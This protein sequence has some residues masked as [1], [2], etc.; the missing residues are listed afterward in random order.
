[1]HPVKKLIF[2][3]CL[4]CV[5]AVGSLNAQTVDT[6][7]IRQI[8]AEKDTVKLPTISNP[9]FEETDS[10]KL[11]NPR[12]RIPRVAAT[13]SAILPGW[14]QVY[15]RKIWK[16]P[17]V[18]AA[19]GFTGGIF[20]NNI[21]WYNRTKYAYRI[22]RDIQE[23]KDSISANSASYM[24]VYDGLRRVFFEGVGGIQ[25]EALRTNRDYF[26]KNVDYA[27][28]YFLIAWGLNVIDAT[29]DAHLSSFD[30]SPD[31][32]FKIQPGYSEMARTAGLSLVLKIK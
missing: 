13:R 10:V 11:K 22:A 4:Y 26:R 3:L 25:P 8:L 30:V 23:G 2:F 16:V 28:I 21:T 18:Y 29:V 5:F 27:A 15:N 24:K 9:A 31:L 1:M 20:V 19:L 32:S 7:I 12:A 17:V 6:A 14:G